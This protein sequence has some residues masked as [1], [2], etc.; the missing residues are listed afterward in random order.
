[1]IVSYVKNAQNLMQILALAVYAPANGRGTLSS[2]RRRRP[3]DNGKS[4]HIYGTVVNV[5]IKRL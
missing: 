5:S 4:D 1:M 3:L 2:G